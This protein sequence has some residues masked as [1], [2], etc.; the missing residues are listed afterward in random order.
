[1]K[2]PSYRSTTEAA[3]LREILHDRMLRNGEILPDDQVSDLVIEVEQDHAVRLS[4]QDILHARR[5]AEDD[6]VDS[7]Q[8]NEHDTEKEG[9][10]DLDP[11]QSRLDRWEAF[12]PSVRRRIEIAAI[13]A[14]RDPA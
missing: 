12:R 3:F 14:A 7:M 4:A 6:F 1:M 8:T 13:L 10:S 5:G 9:Y 11:L 2:L